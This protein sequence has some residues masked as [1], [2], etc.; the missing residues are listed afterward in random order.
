MRPSNCRSVR[1][2]GEDSE[3]AVHRVSG[4]GAMGATVG[5]SG[6]NVRPPTR[7]E[8]ALFLAPGFVLEPFWLG[9]LVVLAIC[10][11]WAWRLCRESEQRDAETTERE[12]GA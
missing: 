10:L 7:H 5:P 2:S 11:G 12:R 9:Y 3:K 4:V 8:N 6:D 1:P